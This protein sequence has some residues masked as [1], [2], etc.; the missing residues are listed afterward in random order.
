MG[1]WLRSVSVLGCVQADAGAEEGTSGAVR[2]EDH[3]HGP[4]CRVQGNL[5]ERERLSG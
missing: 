4:G 2:T 5:G 1:F 3:R